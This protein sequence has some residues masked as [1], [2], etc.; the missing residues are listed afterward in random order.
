MSPVS[1]GAPNASLFRTFLPRLVRGAP[2][3]LFL[4]VDHLE[5]QKAGKVQAWVA[6]HRDKI[7]LVLL[8]A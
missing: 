8:P 1:D 4:V 6:Q 5:V 2:R 7:E 3:K